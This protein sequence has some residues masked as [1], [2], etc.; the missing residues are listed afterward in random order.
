MQLQAIFT[1]FLLA[2]SALGLTGEGVCGPGNDNNLFCQPFPD[3]C[4]TSESSP[5]Q[6]GDKVKKPSFS[7]TDTKA[8]E[9]ICVGELRGAACQ[10]QFSSCK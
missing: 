2:G 7:P 10:V 4:G 9:G 3:G 8:N 6:P 1:L 5:K